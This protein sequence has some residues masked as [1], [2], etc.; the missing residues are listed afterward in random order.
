M[1][2][3]QNMLRARVRL[4][5]EWEPQASIML[6]W[7]HPH[8]DWGSNLPA[9]HEA[10]A[11]LAAAL[12]R[13]EPLLITC[14]DEAH[15]AAVQ[16]ALVAR[17]VPLAQ[18]SFVLCPSN[19]VWARDHG[20]I[21]VYQEGA[22]PTLIDFTFNGWGSKF[23]AELDNMLTR[24]LHAAGAFG[25]IDC[26][27]IDWVLEGGGIESDGQGTILTT[28]RCLLAETR[29]P[30]LS[31]QQIEMQLRDRLGAQRVLW[32]E[33]GELE[34]D[35]TDSHVDMLA[36]FCDVNTI[37]YTACDDPSDPHYA[38]LKAMEAELQAFRTLRGEPYRL[39]PLP[40]PQPA[41]A[42]DGHRLPLSYANFLIVNGGV[43][44]PT[45]DDPAD[46]RAMAV[47]RKAF[48]DREIVGVPA[49]PII[50][51][52]GSLHCVSMQLPRGVE[53]PGRGRT[54]IAS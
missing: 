43:I 32:L 50:V 45:Y 2:Y 33:H 25:T 47:L 31:Q 49:L 1:S 20:P 22:L 19:D 37:A 10:F 52:H 3:A 54:L 8:G 39:L 29:N 11:D 18:I 6:T 36:R 28:R 15:L 35:D 26:R 51:Q 7:P 9:A 14:Y 42:D 24:R 53:L 34:G 48:P 16:E 17:G 5:A 23:P 40:W 44:V 41:Y 12:I 27:R 4:P 38:N 46:E 13:F 21:T 30:G